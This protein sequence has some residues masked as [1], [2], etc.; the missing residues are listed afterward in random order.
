MDRALRARFRG[1]GRRKQNQLAALDVLGEIARGAADPPSRSATQRC[2]GIRKFFPR[3]ALKSQKETRRDSVFSASSGM[4]RF[5][6]KRTDGPAL[7]AGWAARSRPCH[8]ICRAHA[9]PWG[10]R[11]SKKSGQSLASSVRRKRMIRSAE[12]NAGSRFFRVCGNQVCDV[13]GEITPP[14]FC[15]PPP[16]FQNL[17]WQ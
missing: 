1:W 9:L 16:S 7:A 10:N 15:K 11:K 4:R 17:F 8:R 2:L 12:N 3:N 5:H 6:C 14:L 13:I